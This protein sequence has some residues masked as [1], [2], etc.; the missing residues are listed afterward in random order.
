M[1]F[2]TAAAAPDAS[3]IVMGDILAFTEII[4]QLGSI[5]T[6]TEFFDP[7]PVLSV[8]NSIYKIFS[9]FFTH[10]NYSF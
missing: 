5:K 7:F 10:R 9:R 6:G 1:N 4:M 2:F 3:S 8:N